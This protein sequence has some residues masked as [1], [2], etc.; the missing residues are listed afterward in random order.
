MSSFNPEHLKV[1][2]HVHGLSATDLGDKVG[3]SHAQIL[4]LERGEAEPRGEVLEALS[5]VLQAEPQFFF[6]PAGDLVQEWQCNFRTPKGTTERTKKRFAAAATVFTMAVRELGRSV[7]MYEFDIPF[8]AVEELEEVEDAA[9]QARIHWDISATAP[10]A[11]VGR[12]AE[13]AGVVITQMD[14]DET[15]TV[16]GFSRYGNI[17]V[18]VISDAKES[19]SRWKFSVAHEMGHGVLGHGGEK[20]ALS[21]DTKELQANRFASSFLMPRQGFAPD[22]LECGYSDDGLF[23]LKERWG[24]SIAAMTFRAHQIGL[25]N[26]AEYRERYRRLSRRGWRKAEPCEP[27]Q[28]QPEIFRLA[29]DEHERLG[30]G[31]IRA[32][33]NDLRIQPELVAKMCNVELPH[34]PHPQVASLDQ[35]RGRKGI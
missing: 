10:L 2:R 31:G 18:I 19:P 32:I 7:P 26:V 20:H 5:I 33:A 3:V 22:F 25:L 12:I 21:H 17:S 29:L 30:N 34:A 35:Y 11:V 1:L 15:G 23:E 24:C 16:D 14:A 13:Q 8:F 28:E 27:E 4:R 6:T 9:V